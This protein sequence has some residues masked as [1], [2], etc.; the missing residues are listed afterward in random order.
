[1]TF[2]LLE[3]LPVALFV[4]DASGTPIYMNPAAVALLGK[5][6]D[7]GATLD[8]L[9]EVYQAFEA[10][11][12]RPYPVERST[13]YRALRDGE[14][15]T[16]DDLEI[17]RPDGVFRL[18]IS[19]VPIL[20]AEGR[21]VA[22]LAAFQ[23]VTERSLA[24]T[25]LRLTHEIALAISGAA[26]VEDGLGLVVRKLGV[27]AEYA[28]G[29]AWVPDATGSYLETAP[30]WHRCHPRYDAFRS[31]SEG[32]T[33]ALGAGL[34]GSVWATRKP[35]WVEDIAT[36][37]RFSRAP[38]AREAG[39][40]S[41]LA[42]PVLAGDE[43]VAVLEFFLD[44]RGAKDDRMLQ[45][46][47]SVAAQLGSLVRRRQA[48]DALRRSELELRALD[49]IKNTFLQGVSHELRTPLGAMRGISVLL[50]RDLDRDL[51]HEDPRL[52]LEQR[53]DLLHRLANTAR[54][55]N[56]LL[57]D[58]LDLDRLVLGILAPQRTRVDVA[59]VVRR[60]AAE[61]ESAAGRTVEIEAESRMMSI[62]ESKLE[63][64]VENLLSNAAKYSPPDGPI[65]VRVLDETDGV[66]LIVEDAG[67]GVPEAMREKVFEPFNRGGSDAIE[68]PG[69]GIG[70]SLVRAFAE[71]HGGGAWIEDRDGG[72]AAFHVQ[73][74]DAAPGAAPIAEVGGRPA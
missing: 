11:T 74:A 43:A 37:P 52:S 73:L 46:V 72:G 31:S 8:S 29:Q 22:A 30:V 53:R 18:Q 56:R 5:D 65:W 40:R 48:E 24:E 44:A 68:A 10:G 21:V 51:A 70:L 2:A 12:D 9:P 45:L 63:R 23:D 42:V 55:M 32:K 66:R 54:T 57:D 26:T 64:I 33:F 28:F 41:A 49:R 36:D 58:L 61:S 69:L 25:E 7:P 47:S 6:V 14:A 4:T 71:L 27:H 39:F 15:S 1:M 50:A 67:E 13:V 59:E 60:V 35:V 3:H 20:D 16:S 62:D 17:H 38:E 19:S 34:P